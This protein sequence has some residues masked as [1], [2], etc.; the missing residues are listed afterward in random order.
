MENNVVPKRYVDIYEKKVEELVKKYKEIKDKDKLF[1]AVKSEIEKFIK[2]C[3]ELAIIYLAI[4]AWEREMEINEDDVVNT[5][6]FNPEFAMD[7]SYFDYVE[8]SYP[9]PFDLLSIYSLVLLSSLLLYSVIKE[10]NPDLLLGPEQ[11]E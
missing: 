6:Y 7:E 3:D 2:K 8:N 11:A 1:R 10:I 9:H 5:L 4:Y